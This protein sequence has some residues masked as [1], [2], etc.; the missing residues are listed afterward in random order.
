MKTGRETNSLGILLLHKPQPLGFSAIMDHLESPG[1]SHDLGK[2]S[3]AAS[4]STT[5]KCLVASKGV[6][7][8]FGQ[9]WSS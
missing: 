8:D 6:R 3:F 7:E 1:G 5:V 9:T 4:S 2:G